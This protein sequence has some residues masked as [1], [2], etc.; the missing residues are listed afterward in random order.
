MLEVD[1]EGREGV[2]PQP[3]DLSNVVFVAGDSAGRWNTGERNIFNESNIVSFFPF[4][5]P[6][7]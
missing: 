1:V 5:T 6:A 2:N 7:L 3:M 4:P